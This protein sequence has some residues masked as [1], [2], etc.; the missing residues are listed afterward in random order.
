MIAPTMNI[1]PVVRRNLENKS[2]RIWTVRT[3]PETRF[4]S[5]SSS[6]IV[7]VASPLDEG[8]RL[9]QIILVEANKLGRFSVIRDLFN[10]PSSISLKGFSF[11]L[12]THSLGRKSGV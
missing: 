11:K 4:P 9:C 7:T 12:Y 2:E 3:L 10:K 5:V 8:R 1:A 6:L